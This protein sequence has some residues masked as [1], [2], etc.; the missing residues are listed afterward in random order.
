MLEY[1]SDE[2]LVQTGNAVLELTLDYQLYGYIS[3]SVA[4]GR[5]T[6]RLVRRNY[7]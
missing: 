6:F 2:V 7:A 5:V 4:V 1:V 3:C